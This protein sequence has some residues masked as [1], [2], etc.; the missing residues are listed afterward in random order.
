ME[1]GSDPLFFGILNDF[2][3]FCYLGAE[4]HQLLSKFPSSKS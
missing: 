1:Q 4:I 2:K 3:E